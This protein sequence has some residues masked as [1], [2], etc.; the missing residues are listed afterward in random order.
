MRNVL[1]GS[2]TIVLLLAAPGAA[3]GEHV[4]KFRAEDGETFTY[5]N[6]IDMELQ[7]PGF[8]VKIK[9]TTVFAFTS[10]S[11]KAP[12]E[13]EGK[14]HRDIFDLQFEIPMIGKISGKV[15][16]ATKKPEAPENPMDFRGGMLYGLWVKHHARVGR[17]FT[18]VVGERG[19]IVRL[20]GV[21]PLLDRVREVIDD[22]EAISPM[23]APGLKRDLTPANFRRLIEGIFIA[24][25][26]KPVKVGDAWSRD[27]QRTMDDKSVLKLREKVSLGEVTEGFADFGVEVRLQKP[28]QKIEPISENP[29][30]RF[31][32]AK[33]ESYKEDM[34][35]LLD[36]SNGRPV[37]AAGVVE[38]VTVLDV[39][40][41]FT[42]EVRKRKSKMKMK[43]ELEY[44]PGHPGEEKEQGEEKEEEGK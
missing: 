16:T 35:G 10:R 18:V 41:T 29:M 13:I 33:A 32:S 21:L 5:T 42:R 25:P 11:S 12:F 27:S 6:K 43:V 17:P 2:M 28:G 19:A 26:E 36:M 40:N 8:S 37:F 20:R 31:V 9:G 34:E 4:L 1:L 44:S 30:E 39:E 24:L 22:D 23:A 38:Y 14:I 15:D 3:R 7:S